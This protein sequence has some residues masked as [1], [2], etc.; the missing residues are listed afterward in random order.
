[1]AKKTKKQI[2]LDTINA[3]GYVAYQ[4]IGGIISWN[5]PYQFLDGS[6]R[7][8]CINTGCNNPVVCSKG[9]E[10]SDPSERSLRTVCA[11]CHNASFGFVNKKGEVTKLK[12]GVVSFKKL[13]CEN[14]DGHITGKRC[15]A[16]S[17]VGGQLELDHIDGA[18]INNVQSNVQTVC[19][20]CHSLKSMQAGDFRKLC[21]SHTSPSVQVPL[22]GPKPPGAPP[23]STNIISLLF[24]CAL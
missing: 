17:L 7:P 3:P 6:P 12:P 21:K 4:V 9:N 16:S 13:I 24:G 20:N 8:K 2:F 22:P 23:N 5:A 18:H 15:T 14:V 1:M 10:K 11:H 19:K